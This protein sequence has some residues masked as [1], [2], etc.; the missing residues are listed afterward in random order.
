MAGEDR[1]HSSPG[2]RRA[3]EA[4]E[5]HSAVFKKQLGLTDLILTQ[6]LFVVGLN[7]VGTAGK[8]GHSHIVYWLLA[9]ALFYI[10]T[11]AV[12]IYLNQLMPLEGGL[13]QWARL[14]FNEFFGFLAAWNLWLYVIMLL[15]EVGLLFATNLGYAL[16]PRVE[17]HAADRSLILFCGVVVIGALA[18]ATIFGLGIGKWIHN[19]GGIIIILVFATLIVLPFIGMAHG[20]VTRYNPFQIEAPAISLLSLNILGKMGFAAL[21]GFEYVAILAGECRQPSRTIGRSVIISAPII[22]LMFI[23]GTSSVLA[24]LKPDDINLIGPIPQVLSIGLKPL[25]LAA[26]IAPVIILAFLGIRLAQ[27]SV[28]FTANSRLPMVAGWDRLLPQWFTHLH[29]KYKTPVNSIIFVGAMTLLASL[30]GMI[31]VAAQEAYQLLQSASVIFYAF[32]YLVMLALPLVGLKDVYPRPPL[33]LKIAACSGFGMTLLNV[34][35]SVFPII[36]VESWWSFGLK[37][38][39]VIVAGNLVGI[40][41]FV[42]AER[43]K[44]QNSISAP[45]PAT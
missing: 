29:P 37:T 31:G 43:R 12:V 23:L 25:G 8:L 32:S 4:V 11:A 6:V 33:W 30:A 44:K 38:S 22:A 1:A 3:E 18:T 17:A 21:G 42:A 16:G 27:A 34:V 36:Q 28:N 40:L 20:E 15:S 45:V 24:F 2:L 10:P 41:I 26:H 35:L 13:Y 39:G 14:G 5:A 9:I 19:A 7:W